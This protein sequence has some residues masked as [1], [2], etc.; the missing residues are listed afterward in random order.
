MSLTP[1]QRLAK[2]IEEH[3]KQ[4]PQS[5]RVAE[6]RALAAID[7][8]RVRTIFPDLYREAFSPSSL[9]AIGRTESSYN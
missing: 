3:F 8:T 6:I 2:A 9:A 5:A 4:M 7:E 1:D